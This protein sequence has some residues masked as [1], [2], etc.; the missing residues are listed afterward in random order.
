MILGADSIFKQPLFSSY[1]EQIVLGLT[2]K[3]HMYK[4]PTN[5]Q[6]NVVL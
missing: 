1:P 3:E 2:K 4:P 5:P 6:S